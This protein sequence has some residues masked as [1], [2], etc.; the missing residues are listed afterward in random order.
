MFLMWLCD[1]TVMYVFGVLMMSQCCMCLVWLYDV[2]V[3]YVFDVIMRCHCAVFHSAVCVW[4]GYDF[5]VPY[6]F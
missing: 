2:T 1:V 3:L 6:V 5:V 4:C